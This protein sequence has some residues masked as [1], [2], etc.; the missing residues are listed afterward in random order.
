M[1]ILRYPGV[2]RHF[3]AREN[4]SLLCNITSPTYFDDYIPYLTN[5]ASVTS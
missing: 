1:G 2:Y 5:K 4:M 3:G